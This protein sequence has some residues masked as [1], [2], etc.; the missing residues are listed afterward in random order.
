MSCFWRTK[1][2]CFTSLKDQFNPTKWKKSFKVKYF[3]WWTRQYAL[4]LLF[5]AAKIWPLGAEVIVLPKNLTRFQLLL[6]QDKFM[7]KV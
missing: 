7:G 6:D 4:F 2:A 3:K 5:V 1:F